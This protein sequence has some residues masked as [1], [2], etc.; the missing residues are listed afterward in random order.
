MRVIPHAMR[1]SSEAGILVLVQVVAM[2]LY[3]RK[4]KILLP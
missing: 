4:E 3:T 1:P 2:L